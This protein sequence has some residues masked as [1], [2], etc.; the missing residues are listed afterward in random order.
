M[1]IYANKTD[2]NKNKIISEEDLKLNN[3][4]IENCFEIK[5]KLILLNILF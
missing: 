4:N 5:C 2:V 1:Y 3:K